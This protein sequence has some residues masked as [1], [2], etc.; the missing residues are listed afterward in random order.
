M[1]DSPRHQAALEVVAEVSGRPVGEL[2]SETELVADL[3]VDSAKALTMLVELE[4]RLG[5]EIDDEEVTELSTV[6]D[7]LRAIEKL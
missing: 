3:G 4:D 2:T 6:G 1:Q 5:I 7:V